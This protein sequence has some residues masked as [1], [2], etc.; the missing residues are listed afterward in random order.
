MSQQAFKKIAEG[1][2]EALVL[3]KLRNL[4][5]SIHD[6]LPRGGMSTDSVSISM[7]KEDAAMLMTAI[8]QMLQ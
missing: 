7:T 2:N 1:L 8:D 4:Q 3:I 5:Q 6:Q